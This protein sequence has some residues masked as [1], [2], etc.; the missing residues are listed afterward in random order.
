MEGCIMKQFVISAIL[1]LA[2][3]TPAIAHHGHPHHSEP[4]HNINK[5]PFNNRHHYHHYHHRSNRDWVAPAVIIGG[6]VIAAEIA[7]QNEILREHDRIN[8]IPNR[9]VIIERQVICSDWR[10]VQDE[11]GRIY[12]ER[13]CR[14][15]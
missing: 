1:A 5:P 12:R 7:R 6:A 13:V 15:N 8:N 10:E 2:S 9:N 4:W 11:D 14:S 3:I